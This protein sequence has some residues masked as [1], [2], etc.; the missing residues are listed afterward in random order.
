MVRLRIEG[1]TGQGGSSGRGR[2]VVVGPGGIRG[3]DGS[4]LIGPDEV[5]VEGHRIAAPDTKSSGSAKKGGAA[6]ANRGGPTPRTTGSGAG[7]SRVGSLLR[8]AKAASDRADAALARGNLARYQAAVKEMQR[9]V[10]EAHNV[11]A[12]TS[13]V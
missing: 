7:A 2:G 8:R 12:A 13:G 5:V 10:G 11:V 9:L 4:T 1:V 3:E 6:P